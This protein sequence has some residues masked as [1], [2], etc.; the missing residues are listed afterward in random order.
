MIKRS[1]YSVHL[2]KGMYELC[3]MRIAKDEEFKA[4]AVKR[5]F[6][7]VDAALF[8]EYRAW[9]IKKTLKQVYENSSFYRR[10]FDKHNVKPE[11][12]NSMEDLKKFP[13]TFPAD[14]SGTS[15]SLLCTSQSQVEKPVFQV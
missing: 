1:E 5:N 13:F 7:A 3:E 4:Q 10:L 9:Q 12:F 15:Y 11:D 8:D 2:E 6:E 14:L